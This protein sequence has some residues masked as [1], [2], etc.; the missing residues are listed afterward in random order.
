ME[1]FSYGSSDCVSST[2][3]GEQLS[4]RE[5]PHNYVSSTATDRM[6]KINVVREAYLQIH[7]VQVKKIGKCR[8]QDKALSRRKVPASK[9]RKAN[10]SKPTSKSRKASAKK[11]EPDSLLMRLVIQIMNIV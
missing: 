9:S 7:E 8:K 4:D 10:T 1:E 3:T 11:T 2:D 6:A 5:L